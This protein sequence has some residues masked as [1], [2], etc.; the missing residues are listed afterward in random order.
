MKGKT[1]S[2]KETRDGY[3]LLSYGTARKTAKALDKAFND[4]NYFTPTDIPT[5]ISCWIHSTATTSGIT[6]SIMYFV[7]P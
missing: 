1:L 7:T 2:P 5:L 3:T 6:L 4:V